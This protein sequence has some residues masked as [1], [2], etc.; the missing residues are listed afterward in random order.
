MGEA[1]L[2]LKD[3]G[4]E[5]F[6]LGN[7]LKAAAI[8]TKAI[9]Q[10][11]GNAVV[12]S[13]RCA[14]FLKLS[15]VAKAL[16]DADQCIALKP[17]WEKGYFRR[18]LALEALERP[19]EALAAFQRAE[20]I[21]PDDRFISERVRSLSKVVRARRGTAK[22][23]AANGGPAPS[24]SQ[25]ANGVHA[26]ID[27]QQQQAIK[28]FEKEILEKVK[29][30]SLEPAELPSVFCLPGQG[31]EGG[32]ELLQVRIKTAFDS[33]DMLQNCLT[34]LRE[35]VVEQKALAACAVI[36]QNGVAFPQVWK[37]PGWPYEGSNGTFVQLES[38]SVK[39]VWYF[40]PITASRRNPSEV[41]LDFRLLG[42]IFR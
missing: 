29:H 9:K 6:K 4:N 17:D 21:K 16:A 11:P 1:A 3:Q 41:S 23:D 36:P 18:G 35:Y 2:S 28:R 19:E 15:K 40:P 33:P 34:Y 38:P 13:N 24:A 5:E 42:S 37:Q 14:S 30:S 8:Y 27:Q 22:A 12:Y 25:P 20:K 26:S 10:D 39:R 32:K 31:L 7:W